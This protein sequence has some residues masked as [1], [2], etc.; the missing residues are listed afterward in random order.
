MS[1]F[2][3]I[4]DTIRDAFLSESNFRYLRITIDPD[5]TPSYFTPMKISCTA[6]EDYEGWNFDLK[7]R[8]GLSVG[9]FANEKAIIEIS[10]DGITWTTVFTGF[11]SDDGLKR[12]RGR[13]SDDFI[14]LSLVDATKRKGTKRTPDSALLSE[15]K[16]VDTAN[17]SGSVL[18]YLASLMG[19]EV[20]T[21]DISDVLPIAEIGES[22]VWEELQKLKESYHADMYFR[23]DGKLLFRSPLEDSYS[24]P[25]SEWTFRGDPDIPPN[26]N[27]S[28]IKKKVQEVYLP[29]RANYGKC[30]FDELTLLAEQ[31][32]YKNTEN[33]NATYD[34][35]NIEVE[36]GGYWPGPESTDVA[37]LEYTGPDSGEDFPYAI[38]VSTPTIGA[39]GSTGFDIEYTGSTLEITSFNGSTSAT[40]QGADNSQIILHNSGSSTAIIRKLTIKGKPYSKKSEQTVEYIDPSITDA[41]DYVESEIDGK[42]VVSSTRAFDCLYYIVQ[43]GKGR[44][45]QFSISTMFMPWIQRNAIVNVQLPDESSVRCR[46]DTYQHRN[47]GRT[48]QGMYTSLICTQLGTFTPTGTPTQKITPTIPAWQAKLTSISNNASATYRSASTIIPTNPQVGDYW[49][50]TDS[51]LTKRYDGSTWQNVGAAPFDESS[52]SGIAFE[53]STGK[54][55]IYNDGSFEF[56]NLNTAKNAGGIGYDVTEDRL[57]GNVAYDQWDLVVESDA[58]LALL[59]TGTTEYK[60]VLITDSSDYTNGAVSGAFS[61]TDTINLG[62]HG[63]QRFVGLG[64]NASIINANFVL[65]SF[66][67]VISCGN[68]LRIIS[69]IAIIS[70]VTQTDNTATVLSNFSSEAYKS[71]AQNIFISNFDGACIGIRAKNVINCKVLDVYIG[72]KI[73]S[74]CTCCA[75]SDV[76]YAGFVSCIEMSNCDVFNCDIGFFLSRLLTSCTVYDALT[77]GFQKC[78]RISSSETEGCTTGFYDSDYISSCA[79]NSGTNGYIDCKHVQCSKSANSSLYWD[80]C[81]SSIVDIIAGSVSL[82]ADSSTTITLPSSGTWSCTVTNQGTSTRAP[83]P[84]RASISGTTLTITNTDN[85]SASLYYI[86]IRTA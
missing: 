39:Y 79:A 74:N 76:S 1:Y 14:S 83:E 64:N 46:I 18:H 60:N 55:K 81:T 68:D 30:E 71:S 69:D 65:D 19:V 63:V 6:S 58:D 20:A 50:Q 43:E 16:I 17:T 42:Y 52:E 21:S 13:I 77:Y 70:S 48:L 57:Y 53:T 47:Q 66:D 35:I 34:Y 45:R 75:A 78:T 84:P 4:S 10:A 86:A 41:I 85:D 22:T 33:Y 23:Y 27:E 8:D 67:Y 73:C 12:T 49:Y 44:P 56:G 51:Q 3:P 37:K 59:T 25:T 80:N 40:S 61:V 82:S 62:N 7:N 36:A 72:F 32:I 11:A 54:V 2:V 38:D 5:G 31:V 26:G 24:A 29:V 28:W 9:L 15:F